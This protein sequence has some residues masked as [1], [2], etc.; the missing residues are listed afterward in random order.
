MRMLFEVADL[1]VA[2]PATVSRCGMVYITP[3]PIG[4]RLY[5]LSWLKTFRTEMDQSHRDLILSLFDEHFAPVLNWR[6][7]ECRDP[8][9]SPDITI[10]VCVLVLV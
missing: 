1:A 9:T 6:F 5:V 7:K 3:L 8:I 10:A 2:S 4:W